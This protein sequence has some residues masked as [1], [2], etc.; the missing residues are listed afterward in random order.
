[1][2]V[3]LLVST[4][5]LLAGSPAFAQCV[6]VACNNGTRAADQHVTDRQPH[7]AQPTSH[8]PGHAPSH[9]PRTS[10]GYDEGFAAGLAARSSH[11]PTGHAS[12][13]S[14]K[15]APMRTNR[16][17]PT[18]RTAA[19]PRTGHV[20]ANRKAATTPHVQTHSRQTR[21]EQTRLGQTRPGQ[22]RRSH[23]SNTVRRSHAVQHGHAVP[24]YNDPIK[25]RAATYRPNFYGQSTALATVMTSSSFSSSSRSSTT[26]WSGA[27]ASVN[28]GG[29]M[30][31]WGTQIVTSSQ[32]HA[33]S[34]SV[35]VCQDSQGWRPPGY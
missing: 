2:R 12:R 33:Q 14:G 28:H 1:M 26:T 13:H 11:A 4:F 27:S 31:G 25:D 17:P 5:A 19:T 30:C 3:A 34:Q 15:A 22:T 35:W 21:P 7:T 24:L 29:Q 10:P 32:S 6:T 23:A 18:K 9:G 16:T 20:A 8:A